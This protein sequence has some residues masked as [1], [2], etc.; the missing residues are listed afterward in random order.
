MQIG[1]RRED[2]NEWE[3][4][5][6]LIPKHIKELQ[7]KYNFG[8]VVQPSKI[9]IFPN[10]EFLKAGAKINEDLSGCDIILAIKEIPKELFLKGKTYIFFSHTT[11]GQKYN[12]SMLKQMIDLKTTLIDYEHIVDEK[13]KRLVFFGRFAGIAGMIDAFWALGRRLKWEG[14]DTPFN[15]LSQ[16]LNYP[17]LK[18]AKSAFLNVSDIIKENGLPDSIFPLVVGFAGYGNVSLGAQ[19]IFDLMPY[20]SIEP[21]NLQKFIRE[22]NSSRNCLYKVVFKEIDVVQPIDPLS[23]FEFQDYYDHPEKYSSQFDKYL[24]YLTLLING[25]YWDSRYPKLVTKNYLKSVYERNQPFSLR[26]IADI[27]CDVNGS[28]ECNLTTTDSGNPI[29]V[30]NPIKQTIN[31]EV[32][33]K[34]PVVLAVDNLPCELPRESSIMFSNVLKDFIP[35]LIK[36][37]FKKTFDKLNIPPELKRAIILYK[38][39]LITEYQYLTKYL[40]I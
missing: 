22:K 2:K 15:L 30:Y 6:P 9:R 12:I 5:V 35:D 29:Y 27:T 14:Y 8:F 33:G 4:R 1:I 7:Q 24:P 40:S 19:E 37:D 11:K 25:I 3:A 18:D 34:G 32:K 10:N 28:I 23:E 21:K 36:A 17:S 13:G 38:G 39:E 20:E 26:I 31:Y 16:A